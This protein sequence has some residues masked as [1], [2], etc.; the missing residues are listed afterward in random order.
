MLIE[1]A[2][3]RHQ[4]HPVAEST[5]L[6]ADEE[7]PIGVRLLGEDYVLWRS[8]DGA[9]VAAPDRCPIASRRSASAP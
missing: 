5:D 9:V 3:L 6:A 2:A 1:H 8:P 7:T 4:W